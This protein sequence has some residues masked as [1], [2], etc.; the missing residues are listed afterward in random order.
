[1]LQDFAFTGIGLGQFDRVLHALYVPLLNGP[2]EVVPHAH[3]L[4]LE[5]ALELGIPG[6]V[7]AMFLVV[8][9]FRQCLR[10]ARSSDP[11][12]RWVGIGLGIGML[13]YF[14]YGSVDAIA[15]GARAGI[16]LWI[17]LGLGAAVGNIARRSA[18]HGY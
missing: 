14:V 3:N 2:L 10:A 16:V 9:F 5:Y 4:F 6:A 1:M 17:V 7:A 18:Q 12:V 11:L 13:G 15:P 8:A